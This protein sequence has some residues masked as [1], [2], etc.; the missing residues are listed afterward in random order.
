MLGPGDVA[1]DA[2]RGQR[3][4]R[5]R[6]DRPRR[7][8]ARRG[9]RRPGR[10]APHRDLVRR[11]RGRRPTCCS[12]SRSTRRGSDAVS[13]RCSSGLRASATPPAATCPESMPLTLADV[14]RAAA[15]RT[16]RA[17][18]PGP[19]SA[20]APSPCARCCRCARCPT[21]SSCVLGLDQDALPPG[22][23]DGD[24]LLGPAAR[25]G[26][27]RAAG[28]GP[29]AAARGGP[30]G[31]RRRGH[32][33]HRHRRAHQPAGAAGGGR[34]T[35][36]GTA[37]PPHGACSAPTL[38]R[39]ARRSSTPARRSIR[40]NFEAPP[41][42]FDPVA[43]AGAQA[44]R[45]SDP[46]GRAARAAGGRRRSPPL[47][48]D[49]VDLADLRQFLRHPVR[50]VLPAAPRGPPA[51]G[52]A[53]RVGHARR[54][55]STPSR[56]GRW[57]T[58]C[59]T[60]IVTG[61]DPTH[62]LRVEQARGALPAAA[63][64]AGGDRPGQRPRSRPCS[65]LRRDA[66]LRARPA[67]HHPI[68]LVGRPACA[69]SASVGP[70]AGGARP[71]PVTFTYSRAKPSHRLALWLDLLAL[72]LLDPTVEWR[73]VGLSRSDKKQDQPLVARPRRSP[74]PMRPSGDA[75]AR[76]GARGRRRAL[77]GRHARSRSRCS[78]ARPA[79]LLG[80]EAPG[81]RRL[82][83]RHVRRVRRRP[84]PPGLRRPHRSP[85]SSGSGS[86]GRTTAQWATVL[87]DAVDRSLAGPSCDR[88]DPTRRE[89]SQG[90]CSRSTHDRAP[91]ARPHRPRCF[92]RPRLVIEASAG[93]GK[94]F[95][96]AALVVALRGRGRA[97]RSTRSWW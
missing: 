70:C 62:W 77:P 35:S 61:V 21:G 90:R 46:R 75:T 26:R 89:P 28:R 40:S 22:G 8:H 72:T 43:L 1:P 52:R 20:A 48:A 97:S 6:P 14:R 16:S 30:G 95:T 15:R 13:T 44:F 7:A 67:D 74:G 92:D 42:S 12:P 31:P 68:D 96:L 27:S 18:R 10:A 64:G 87:W 84:P 85:S 33:L 91:A 51:A 2:G 38:P 3:R 45:R 19:P 83:G 58:A 66:W 63:L 56:A 79:A 47:G 65:T 78:T 23:L 4:R 29:S 60:S 39:P 50:S 55:S 49:A 34:S 76:P 24:D 17:I 36:C 80:P 57:A 73:A 86:A 32:H 5:R 11:P 25:R 82:A 94:T 37:W 71:G 53:G 54:S 41:R 9:G 88:L 81:G 69:S 59:S 93:T